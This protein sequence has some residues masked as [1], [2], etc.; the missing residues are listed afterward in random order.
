MRSVGIVFMSQILATSQ[1]RLIPDFVIFKKRSF[2]TSTASFA[3]CN[4][5]DKGI[6]DGFSITAKSIQKRTFFFCDMNNN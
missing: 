3:K 6:E 2:M 5:C 1:S 4:V